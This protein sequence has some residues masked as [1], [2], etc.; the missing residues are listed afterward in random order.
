MKKLLLF[1]MMCLAS[2]TIQ[3]QKRCVVLDFQIGTNVTEEEIDGIS[4]CF[5]SNFQPTGYTKV[6]QMV[7][8]R[9]IRDFGFSRTD[10]TQQQIGRVG[11]E[12]EA[13]IVV[14]GTINKFMDEYSVD[15]RVIDVARGNTIANES[16]NFQKTNYRDAMEKTAKRLASKLRGGSSTSLGTGTST[17][18]T[19]LGLPSGTIWKDIN[20]TGFYTYDEAFSQFG[21]RLPSK[22]QWEELKAECKWSWNGNGYIVTGPNGNS[23]T[24]P[25]EGYRDCDGNLCHVGSMPYYWSSTS[26]DA[27]LAYCLALH[28]IRFY[29]DELERRQTQ[30]DENASGWTDLIRNLKRKEIQDLYNR[31]QDLNKVSGN[32]VRMETNKQCMGFSVRLVQNP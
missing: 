19:D 32:D 25:V 16:A 31:I 27:N 3:A 14:V 23:I 29:Q 17:G 4:Y 1:S 30:Y 13:N 28:D 9:A 18:Y 10:M 26:S 8:T 15:I 12:L 22:E 21:D 11:R 2:L 24:L 7:V 5:R 20:A 6:E